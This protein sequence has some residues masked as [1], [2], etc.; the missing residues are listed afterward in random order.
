MENS[1]IYVEMFRLCNYKVNADDIDVTLEFKT[2]LASRENQ[3]WIDSKNRVWKYFLSDKFPNAGENLHPFLKDFKTNNNNDFINLHVYY[4]ICT[5]IGTQFYLFEILKHAEKVLKFMKDTITLRSVEN[6]IIEKTNLLKFINLFVAKTDVIICFN[7]LQLEESDSPENSISNINIYNSK[8]NI[9]ENEKNDL[10]DFYIE[11]DSKRN[12]VALDNGDKFHFLDD[13]DISQVETNDKNVF[14]ATECFIKSGA[15]QYAHIEYPHT[16]TY[17]KASHSVTFFM[18]IS[19]ET[20]FEEILYTSNSRDNTIYI[21]PESKTLYD[22][23]TIVL[24][25]LNCSLIVEKIIV[26]NNNLF[27]IFNDD[28]VKNYK[29]P[30]L[31]I[32]MNITFSQIK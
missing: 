6:D 32:E 5:Y 17:Q 20:K 25:K 13:E 15:K 28:K 24:Q 8:I 29:D 1:V 7:K 31:D 9:V 27:M 12:E 16:D 23:I 3:M 19:N 22:K 11:D 18:M 10:D 21:Y 14:I 2:F 26:S 30:I 4:F